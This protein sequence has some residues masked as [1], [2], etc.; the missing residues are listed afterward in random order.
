MALHDNVGVGD[1]VLLDRITM[2]DFIG[3]LHTRFKSGKIY[4]YIG[5]VCV[6]VNPYKTLNIYDKDYVNQY[7]GREQFE[8]APHLFAIAENAYQTMRRAGKD[9]CIMISGESGSGKTEASKIIM[10]YI[11]AITNVSGHQEVERVK[12]VLLQSNCILEGFGNARTSRNDNS[13]R[14]GKYMDIQFDW[15]GD[16][17]GGIIENYLL[18]KSR[19][20]R[21][22]EKERNFHCF[23]QLIL[24]GSDDDLRRRDLNRGPESYNYVSQGGITRVD[25]INDRQDFRNVN[26]A[27]KSLGVHDEEVRTMWDVVGAILH[28]GNISFKNSES[29][30]STSVADI[31]KGAIETCSRLLGVK[32]SELRRSLCERAI[33]AG[34]QVVRKQLTSE[35][36]IYARDALGKAVYERL[37]IWIVNRINEAIRPVKNSYG[38]EK[39]S[40][41]GVLDIYGFEI[42]DTNSFEQFCINYCNEKLQQLFI[43]LVLKQ[44][45]EEYR[46]EGIKWTHIDY[47][48]NQIICD[49]V[50]L[51]HKGIISI[52]DEACLSV[53]HIT[54]QVLLDAMDQKLKGHGH[55]TSRRLSPSDKSLIHAQDFR[56]KHY[57]GDVTYKIEGMLDKN[58]DTLFQDLKRVLYQSS[59]SIISS[60]WPDGAQDITKTTKRPQTAG[61]IFKNS[62]I[63]LVKTLISKE[64]YYVRCIKP[65]EV[66][67]PILFDTE[68]VE[69]QVAY[70]GLLENVRVRRAGFAHRTP[71]ERFV[72]R[73]KMLSRRTWPNP[74][75]GSMKD[76]TNAIISDL[77]LGKDDAAVYG[78]TKV[79]IR[80]PQT[81]F[82]LE[83][84]RTNMIPGIVT[85]LQK[86]WRGYMARQYYKRLRAAHRIKGAYRMYKLRS[87]ITEVQKVLGFPTANQRNSRGRFGNQNHQQIVQLP[88][89]GLNVPWPRAPG[90]LRRVVGIIQAAYG[91]W[92]ALQILR[93]VPEHDWPVLRQKV[94][95]HTALL[96]GR[97]RNWGMNRDW[98]GDYLPTEGLNSARDYQNSLN[99]VLGK[100]GAQ[101]V[102][103]SSRILKATPGGG[104]KFAERSILVTDGLIFKLDG[105]KGAFKSMKQWVSMGEIRAISITPGDDQLVVIHVASGRD[106]VMALH[107]GVLQGVSSWVLNDAKGGVPPDLIG[108]FVTVIASQCLSFNRI[109]VPVNVAQSIEC[110][111]GKKSTII[112]VNYGTET[113]VPSFAKDG[114][115]N[116]LVLTWPLAPTTATTPVRNGN[117][118]YNNN[119]ANGNGVGNVNGN[120]HF[121][122]KMN[123]PP[124]PLPQGRVQSTNGY[125]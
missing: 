103:F 8:R 106:L 75:G 119:F 67:S 43:E 40:V 32:S 55:Y 45:Q 28:L 97:R 52:M 113:T 70:L 61:T 78:N 79:F 11:A 115:N 9:T 66:K 46:R 41:I 33:A 56:I 68:R 29:G 26:S 102:I 19:V 49:L 117:N 25:T 69:H 96:K 88:R 110:K 94:F 16:P 74:R 116:R 124:P 92:W 21:Q 72:K 108:E 81:L 12:N 122:P 80:S 93:Q 95:C 86:M 58:K 4:T 10:R 73:Y 42:L 90:P 77:R 123:A 98:K 125:H 5:E 71:Y 62:M 6:S 59:N 20:V 60:M 35:A 47:F 53:G 44:E 91:R 2:D 105:P 22:Q 51:P 14:F 84:A 7:K 82:Q 39:R 121:K 104:G 50:E 15:K 76:A 34:G 83:K 99:R 85:F 101:R 31:S 48:N 111:L 30:E 89:C 109:P 54:D 37:F 118:G 3:N 64:P 17:I 24:G 18:E 100:D 114:A 107:C 65:N 36:G 57:A 27:L 38:T 87:Y 1:F 13:S 23:Y 120:G 112:R 63:A